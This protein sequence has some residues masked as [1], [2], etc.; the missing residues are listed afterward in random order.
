[1]PIPSPWNL[2]MTHLADHRI[3]SPRLILGALS[4]E[5]APALFA[6]RGDPEVAR[7]QGW[8]PSDMGEATDFIARNATVAFGHADAW[9]QLAIRHRETIALIGDFGIHFP[10]SK[11]EAV[12]LG[13]SLMPAQ[14]GNGYAREAMR[15]V[16][17]HLF[18]VMD[19]R[20]VIGSVDPRNVASVAL[21]RALGMRREA[22]HRQSL[23][24][25]GEWV[26]DMIFAVLASEWPSLQARAEID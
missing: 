17:A 18:G 7:Y 5:D 22:H 19:Y 23:Y 25:R 24:W 10:A 4:A 8:Q 2:H 21:L 13:I 16:I 1:M 11:N 9:C 12:E 20:R 15:A 3:E 14:Q 26:D 6:C